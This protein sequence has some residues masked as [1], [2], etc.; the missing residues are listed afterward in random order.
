[1]R[2][3]K[4]KFLFAPAEDGTD[5]NAG[6]PAAPEV[7]TTPPA[8]LETGLASLQKELE[9]VEKKEADAAVIPPQ[10]GTPVIPA[11]PVLP[12]TPNYKYKH[13]DKE[14][15]FDA[16]FKSVIK[17]KEDEEYIR[18]L[19]TQSQGFQTY[20]EKATKIEEDVKN[21][22]SPL[23][24]NYMQQAGIINEVNSHLEK[25]DYKSL[26]DRLEIKDEDVIKYA[27]ERVKYYE[28]TPEQRAEID[29]THQD[30]H[31]TFS[32]EQQNQEYERRFSQ[33]AVQQTEMQLDMELNKV[34]SEVA[35]Y[36]SMAGQPGAFKAAVIQRA[37]NAWY[38]QKVN[39][40]VDQAVR[41]TL[42]SVKGFLAAVQPTQG[43][44][45]AAN[46]QKT[47]I[48][49]QDQKPTIPILPGNGGVSPTHKAIN[50]IQGL[51]E[52]AAQL[53]SNG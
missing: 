12:Y 32:L 17:N 49:Q 8:D 16:R 45:T 52:K 14:L 26:F 19:Y 37:K 25:K 13:L 48:V 21:Y 39:L 11:E 7:T 50:S 28:L 22:Y 20:K 43:N 44:P 34:N 47:V 35:K 53:E 41:D 3:G 40:P 15:E 24:Q 18:N 4:E 46:P 27:M 31:K 36:D 6:T 29:R 2:Y 51:K 38:E 1:M 30:R 33:V 42:E 5:V 9:A 10:E 23:E